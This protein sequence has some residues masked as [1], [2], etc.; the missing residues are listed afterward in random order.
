MEEK[1]NSIQKPWYKKWWVIS[2]IILGVIGI[3]I[4]CTLFFI[5]TLCAVSDDSMLFDSMRYSTLF[6]SSEKFTPIICM[7]ENNET[8]I[9]GSG[10]KRHILC[11]VHPENKTTYSFEVEKI[12]SLDGESQ[13][14][15]DSWIVNSNWEGTV[16]TGST[17][18]ILIL[19]IPKKIE[20]TT[21]R[22]VLK[23]KNMDNQTEKIHNLYIYIKQVRSIRWI[24][25]WN[26]F[27]G[28]EA[29]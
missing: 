13:E 27:R 4:I 24:C 10:G 17:I 6:D 7:G 22:I 11:L 9:L 26:P 23:E 29:L 20:P 14:E 12:I 3:G 1:T 28:D 15:V 25:K 16:V 8:A 5:T 2:L 18:D 21:I 19:D